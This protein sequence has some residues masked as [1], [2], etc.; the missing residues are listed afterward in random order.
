MHLCLKSLDAGG[1]LRICLAEGCYRLVEGL[2]VFLQTRNGSLGLFVCLR[3]GRNLQVACE[4][5]NLQALVNQQKPDGKETLLPVVMLSRSSPTEVFPEGAG[6]GRPYTQ[7]QF[8]REH[9]SSSPSDTAYEPDQVIPPDR[10][11]K[12]VRH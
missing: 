4:L 7:V 10:S 2:L 6:R 9:C 1:L 5:T 12:N 11:G 8:M 3:Q